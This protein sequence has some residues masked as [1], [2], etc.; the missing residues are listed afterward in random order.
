MYKVWPS[1]ELTGRQ[2]YC[3]ILALLV[4][5]YNYRE[6]YLSAHLTCVLLTS[7]GVYTYRDLWPL[8]TINETEQD[9]S[10]GGYLWVKILCLATIGM[11]LPLTEPRN[12]VPVDP[13]VPT[14][15]ESLCL[16]LTF[17][18]ESHGRA[19]C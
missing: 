12:Y 15:Y 8:V 7:L 14:I 6:E 3:S 4:V 13:E 18:P 10:D 5:V 1:R 16:Q 9:S 11:I 17:L 19:F 2:A